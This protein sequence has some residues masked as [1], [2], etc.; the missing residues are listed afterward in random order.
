[1]LNFIGVFR[2]AEQGL[3]TKRVLLFGISLIIY[4]L[5]TILKYVSKGKG[6]KMKKMR[7]PSWKALNATLLETISVTSSGMAG[8]ALLT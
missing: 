6:D 2:L 1:M 5:V 3:A 4:I 8:S 7:K